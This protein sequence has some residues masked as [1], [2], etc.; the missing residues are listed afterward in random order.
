M[1]GKT[2]KV[3]AIMVWVDGWKPYKIYGKRDNKTLLRARAKMKELKVKHR[4]SKSFRIDQIN[5][6]DNDGTQEEKEAT[7]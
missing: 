2:V 5:V 6:E 3:W 4:Y 7:G 1:N